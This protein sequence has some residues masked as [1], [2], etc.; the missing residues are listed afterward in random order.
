MG[1]PPGQSPAHLGHVWAAADFTGRHLRNVMAASLRLPN[2]HLIG[3]HVSAAQNFI[4]LI[5]G[6]GRVN[7]EHQA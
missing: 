1:S 7:S 6:W 5:A 2:K 3:H 4:L